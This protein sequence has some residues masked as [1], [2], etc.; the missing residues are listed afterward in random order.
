MRDFQIPGRSVAIGT[1][2]MVATSNPQAAMAGLD[3][4]RSGGNAVDAAVAIAGMLA[5]V[6]P[7][8]TGI[9][10]DCFALLKRPGHSPIALD[11]SG[12]APQHVN[13]EEARRSSLGAIPPSSPLAV[14][15]PGAVGAWERLLVDYGTRSFAELLV[16]AIE[17]AESG[18]VVTERL[19]RDWARQT[20]KMTATPEATELFMGNG[21]AP[22]AGDRRSNRKLGCTLRTIA[23]RGAEGFY[24]GSVAEDIVAFLRRLG[25]THTLDDFA[26]FSPTYVDPISVEYRGYRLWEC[27]P[28]GQGVVALQIAGMLDQFDISTLDPLGGE[29]FHLQA[30]LSRL[31][32]A[33]RDSFIGDPAFGRI[34][35]ETMLSTAYLTR[36]AGAFD[37]NTRI[38][39]LIPLPVPEHRDTVYITVADKDGMVVS[40]INS[41]FDDF[42]SG[43]VA[44]Q[45]GV[46]L[47]N[48]GCGFVLDYGHPN[49]LEGRKRPMHTIIPALL[50]KGDDAVMSFG[51]TGGHFQ[52][53][54]QIQILSNIIDY[55]MSVQQAIEFPRMFARG[56]SF[57]V[58][59]TV[60]ETVR[61]DLERRGHKVS[62]AENPLGTCHAIYVDRARGVFLGG[63]DG[64]RDGLAIG[65]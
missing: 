20:A 50:T 16:P 29:R 6:E 42:G 57:E 58:E 40:F 53:T 34:D 26:E 55:G 22:Q 60:P 7:T 41:I 45:S 24:S 8:Q 43:L 10:G 62:S 47:H 63:S 14:T 5:V 36:L 65:Y 52:P 35:V 59:R 44:P 30:E 3:I 27:P 51:V 64:R 56:D 28:G 15:V 39:H 12:W 23:R 38:T 19:A 9:G 32:Y 49:V 46:L 33:E 37:S 13:V 1:S 54:G 18:Y 21:I 17:A 25:G 48:R 4:L 31:A 61:N 2:G 11:G